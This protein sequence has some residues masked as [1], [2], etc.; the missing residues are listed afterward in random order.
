MTKHKYLIIKMPENMS[1]V[2]E[3]NAMDLLEACKFDFQW[4]NQGF[5]TDEE[6]FI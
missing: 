4:Y 3:L 2:D 6:L 5:A 1:L